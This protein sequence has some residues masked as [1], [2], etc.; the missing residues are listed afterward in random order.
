MYLC[1][2]EINQVPM[3][4]DGDY[5]E[6][7]RKIKSVLIFEA[8]QKRKDEESF[9]YIKDFSADLIW[10]L[11]ELRIDDESWNKIK[12]KKID[13]KHV[14]CHPDILLHNP[15][16]SIHYRGLCNLSI[17]SV[18]DYVGA[19][20]SLEQGNKRARL[21][22]EKAL[23]MA[24]T[25]NKFISFII[26]N[27]NNWNLE[28]GSRSIVATL[29][30][31]LDG[32]NRNKVG[33]LAESRM[34]DLFVKWLTKSDLIISKINES[35]YILRDNI[36]MQF[37]S[38]PDISFNRNGMLLV[39]VE[40]K[41]GIDPAGALERYGAAIKSFKDAVEKNS[42]CGTF[43]LAAV[44]TDTLR[45]RIGADRMVNHMFNI[46][47]ILSDSTEEEEF[48]KELFHHSLRIM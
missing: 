17:K 38:D 20:E 8:L 29:G 5:A 27:T 13:P 9:Q 7:L 47:D 30:I 35:K 42:H 2:V 28:D 25:Y 18:K 45:E 46:A 19:I 41:G 22:K 1:L 26:R 48:F 40:I 11:D 32:T 6:N 12:D 36:T 34:H 31:S 14:F 23:K 24:R 21:S 16:T 39:V 43:Y 10:Q 4:D 37:A 3:P 15:I 44:I 33:E